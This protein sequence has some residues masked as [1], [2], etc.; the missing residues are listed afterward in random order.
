MWKIKRSRKK[1]VEKGTEFLI[2]TSIAA[3]RII[4]EKIKERKN[5]TYI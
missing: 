3:S 4:S 2:D 5:E 1:I